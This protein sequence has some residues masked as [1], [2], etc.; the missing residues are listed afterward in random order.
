MGFFFYM[1]KNENQR[2]EGVL[3]RRYP[4]NVNTYNHYYVLFYAL[5]TIIG[6]QTIYTLLMIDILLL[7]S[8]SWAIIV[9]YEILAVAFKNIGQHDANLYKGET[10]FLTNITI[11]VMRNCGVINPEGS[12]VK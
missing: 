4:L 2:L 6:I 3:N 5:E 10:T 1:R 7:F 8:I 11:C 9:Q 12:R